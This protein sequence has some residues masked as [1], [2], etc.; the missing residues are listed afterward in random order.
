MGQHPRRGRDPPVPADEPP[1]RDVDLRGGQPVEVHRLRLPGHQPR[2]VDVLE[3][4]VPQREQ[5][6]APPP[7]GPADGAGTRRRSSARPRAKSAVKASMRRWPKESDP[8]QSAVVLLTSTARAKAAKK[9]RRLPAVAAHR[10]TQP[11]RASDV[12]RRP[13]QH[14]VP[15]REQEVEDVRIDAGHEVLVADHA[16]EP[17]AVHGEPNAELGQAEQR[18]AGSAARP[19]IAT[20]APRRRARSSTGMAS[21]TTSCGRTRAARPPARPTSAHC[22]GSSP[23]AH[24]QPQPDHRGGGEHRDAVGHRRVRRHVEVQRGGQPDGEDDHEGHR[25]RHVRRRSMASIR[26]RARRSA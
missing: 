24:A 6:R 26:T 17:G 2:V 8:H 9:S 15:G 1:V 3:L 19:A 21:S 20:R 16:R 14:P 23:C 10:T 7:P 22:R 4:Q 12:E 18:R 13:G 5:R 25:A 11:S